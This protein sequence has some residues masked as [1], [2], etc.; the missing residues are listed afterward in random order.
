[1]PY[2]VVA[3]IHWE[4]A[5]RLIGYNGPCARL[6][7]H[8]ARAEI[9]C[10]GELDKS[11]IAV[12]FGHIKELM[13]G[14]VDEEWDHR[15]I[16]NVK[17]PLCASLVEEEKFEMQFNPTAEIMANFLFSLA[18]SHELPVVKVVMWEGYKN[19]ATFEAD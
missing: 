2:T 6:N 10:V 7:G 11:D 12:D 14:F 18:R 19:R 8:S 1:M 13:Q 17:D 3:E 9:H 16:L 15:T 4:Y 5:H